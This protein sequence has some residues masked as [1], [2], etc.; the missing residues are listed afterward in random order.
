MF[1]KISFAG[2]KN[3]EQ[4]AYAAELPFFKSRKNLEFKPGLN[5][6]FGPNGCG[7]STVLKMLGGTMF[8]TQG[9][10]SAITETALRDISKGF[11]TPKD[12]FGLKVLHDGQPVVFADTRN[13]VGMRGGQFDDDFF[14]QGLIAAM[15]SRKS[16][17]QIT[18]SRLTHALSILAGETAFPAEV[19]DKFG[20]AGLNRHWLQLRELAYARMKANID[21]GQPSMLLDEPEANFSLFWQEAVWN[22]LAKVPARN[23]LQVVVASH[24]I[25][26]LG[27]EGANYIEFEDGYLADSQQALARKFA[28]FKPSS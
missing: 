9:G 24:S 23:D 11:G 5:I 4:F 22:L 28:S 20:A 13:Q 8:A 3:S 26:A 6:L 16:H 7:K 21:K 14:Q 17:G 12:S 10:F 25:F 1:Q 27:I 2:L 15:G 19:Q 18:A